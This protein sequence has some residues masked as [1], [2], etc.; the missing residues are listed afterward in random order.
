[1]PRE[2]HYAF[3]M[4]VWRRFDHGFPSL[5]TTNVEGRLPI[6]RDQAAARLMVETICDISAEEPFDLVAYVVMPDHL[7]LVAWPRSPVTTGRVMKMIKGRFARQYQVSRSSRGPFW[8]SRY[9]EQALQTDE[10]LWQA[11]EYVHHNPVAAGLAQNPA[12]YLWSSA[13]SPSQVKT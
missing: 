10:A 3:C 13:R 2:P 4:S 11:I 5:P 12:D 9:H 8:Q 7:H 1:M 6:F